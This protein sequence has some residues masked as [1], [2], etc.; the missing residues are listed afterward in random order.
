[1]SD[2]VLSFLASCFQSNLPPKRACYLRSWRTHAILAHG[3][4]RHQIMVD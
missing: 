2:V 3:L 1:M 4:Q